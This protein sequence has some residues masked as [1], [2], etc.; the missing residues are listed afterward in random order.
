M[1]HRFMRLKMVS[2]IGRVFLNFLL[3]P[4]ITLAQPITLARQS[5]FFS[6]K[7][8]NA[9]QFTK[10]VKQTK[11]SRLFLKPEPSQ[12]DKNPCLGLFHYNPQTKK[13]FKSYPK[14]MVE[15][16]PRLIAKIIL[17]DFNNYKFTPLAFLTQNTLDRAIKGA[18][19]KWGTGPKIP[20]PLIKIPL[21]LTL[22]FAIYEVQQKFILEPLDNF[23]QERVEHLIEKDFRYSFYLEK[24][25][26][27]NPEKNLITNF[28]I[29]YQLILQDYY[30]EL[31]ERKE[32]LDAKGEWEK[33][34][35]HPL[36]QWTVA[37]LKKSGNTNLENAQQAQIIDLSFKHTH[38]LFYNYNFLDH[39]LA[40]PYFLNIYKNGISD[41]AF[42]TSFQKDPFVQG[43]F[44]AYE[45]NLIDHEGKLIDIDRLKYLLQ[46]DFFEHYIVQ[47]VLL[48]GSQF[49]S[50]QINYEQ[51]NYSR[52]STLNKTFGFNFKNFNDFQ[53]FITEN[54][55][56]KNP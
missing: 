50:Y 9:Q 34:K 28:V 52:I 7:L 27:T 41:Y 6:K 31:S 14:K 40:Q 12:I 36:F 37:F 30:Q 13:G 2:P 15:F 38:A 26:L 5:S 17:G 56:E 19:R 11:G 51:F 4:A 53:N 45:R 48:T 55:R 1:L 29:T 54:T 33:Y 18:T 47:L 8:K 42:F 22:T 39:F 16:F 35:D 32:V 21:V 20:T 10:E 25:G 49:E 43:L 24:S 23:T 3:V 44:L 46:K